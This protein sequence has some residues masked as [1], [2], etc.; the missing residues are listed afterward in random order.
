MSMVQRDSLCG[1]SESEQTT[2]IGQ[3]TSIENITEVWLFLRV[4]FEMFSAANTMYRMIMVFVFWGLYND[5]VLCWNENLFV[6][7]S[8]SLYG[9]FHW[10]CARAFYFESWKKYTWYFM[11][12][13]SVQRMPIF[14][15]P[16]ISTAEICLLTMMDRIEAVCYIT[17]SAPRFC[18]QR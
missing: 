15:P 5:I 7:E 11:C 12:K 18:T 14:P 13:R 9:T 16:I 6:Y 2:L 8:S 10:S 1:T 17:F 3:L 4:A